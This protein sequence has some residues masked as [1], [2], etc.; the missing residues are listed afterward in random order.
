[1][2]FKLLRKILYMVCMSLFI[3][4]AANAQEIEGQVRDQEGDPLIGVNIFE[5]D[6]PSR[7]TVSDIDGSFYLGLTS[8]DATVVFSYIGFKSMRLKADEQTTWEIVMQPEVE[9]LDEIVVVGYGVQKKSDLTGSISKIEAAELQKIP[10]SSFEQSLQGKVAG[11]QVT[12]TSGEPGRG[13]TIRIRGVGTLNDA[14]PLYVVDGMLLD[15]ISFL[16][17]QDV[18]S[19]EVL[20]DA[21][22]TAIYGS[23]GA[24]GVIIISTKRGVIGAKPVI[25]VSSYLGWQQLAEKIDLTNARE[26]ALLANELA[27]N[28]NRPKV[29]PDPELFEEG[30]DWQDELYRTAPMQSYNLS[31]NGGN[32]NMRYQISSE[33]FNQDGIQLGSNYQRL[34]LR[35]NNEYTV[36]PAVNVGHN[37]AFIRDWRESAPDVSS[38]AYRADPTIPPRDETGN[39]NDL[40]TNASTGNPLASIF[41]ADSKTKGYRLVG[42]GYANVSLLKHFTFRSNLG[43]DIQQFNGK[44]FTPE[45]F[46]SA[47]QMNEESV[48]TATSNQVHNWLWENTLTYNQ[49]WTDH[50]VTVLGGITS[51]VF[52]SEGLSATGYEL[53]GSS[54]EF[55]YL[56]AAQSDENQVGNSA[57]EWSM[58]SYLFR[59]NYIFR[60]RY[61]FTGS[62]RADGSSRFGEDNRYGYFP[63]LAVGWNLTNEPFMADQTIFSRLKFRASWGVIGNDKIGPYPGRPLVNGPFYYAFGRNEDLNIGATIEGLP[64]A[65]IQ[66]EETSQYNVGFEFGFLDNRLTGEIDY[67]DRVTDKILI[68]LALP[69]HFGIRDNFP[70]V[71]AAKVNNR[72]IDLK[73]DWQ[74]SR[75]RFNYNIG[76]ILSTVENEVLELGESKEELLGGSLGTGGKFGTRTVIGL[77][78]GAFYGYKVDGIF[79]NEGEIADS[80][81]LGGEVPGDLKFV[82]VNGDGVITT[83]DRTYI[84]NPIPDLIWGMHAGFEIAGFD[85]SVDLSGQRGNKLYNAKKMARFGTY[86]FDISYLDRWTGEGASNNEPRI[87]NGGHNYEESE[88]FIENGSYWRIR[89]INIGYTLPQHLMSRFQISRARVYINGTNIFTQ[90][91]YTGFTPEIAGA[92]ILS[93]GIDRGVYPVAKTYNVGISVSF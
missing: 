9:L 93:V 20:K 92:N 51:Q 65:E 80:P 19:V 84:G 88:R 40:S 62:F 67:Y 77:P 11:V 42:N 55:L 37:L 4:I 90:A 18:E 33:F 63:S 27:M 8:P 85:I 71:N 91:D 35:L 57:F 54:S 52:N 79:Q 29:F 87:T 76:L 64:N 70:F 44:F 45:F 46:V 34:N 53:I 14:S 36:H 68:D 78:I 31:V 75:E 15:D 32:E 58:L 56:Q 17:I 73:L 50:R 16:N 24:N 82:D 72:G 74:D 81:T 66:W 21:S 25:S 2:C 13:A 49:E 30:T 6:Y 59:V 38:T 10:T 39:F 3:T 12:P 60:D 23:R 5:E 43:L 89:N 1:M 83:S 47:T 26:Y 22:A 69:G 7:G 48:L 28:E 86:N 41:Y 61:L